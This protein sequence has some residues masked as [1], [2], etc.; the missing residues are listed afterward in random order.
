MNKQTYTAFSPGHISGF[1]EP[2]YYQTD[3]SKSGSRG[4]GINIT[5]GAT[6][7]V[8]ISD[9]TS[10]DINIT[11]NGRKSNA[12]VTTL[13]LKY[14]IGNKQTSINVNTKLDL[15]V[16]QGFGMS[17]AGTLSAALA[18]SKLL[19]LSS[20]DA[21]KAAHFAEIQL[22][23]GLGDVMGMNFGGIEIRKNPGL[24]PWGMV[25]HIPGYFD[26]V[27][28]IL[29]KRIDT[30]KILNDKNQTDKIIEYGKLCTKK[31]L[32]KPSIENFFYLSQLFTNKTGLASKKIIDVI[33]IANNYGMASMCMLG[34]SIFAAGKTPELVKTLAKFG[35]VY[36]C[37]I[38]KYGARIIE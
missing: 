15:P 32:D 20:T 5:L 6:T 22:R 1:F 19:N 16:G 3:N 9:S 21:L 28:C 27:L 12:T 11:I 17:A 23:T 36:L 34:N 30:K 2:V 33:N 18:C 7:Q 38:D 31:I 37:S 13:A 29:G 26:I 25:E 24:P 35:K 10:N 8:M 14:L 4:A